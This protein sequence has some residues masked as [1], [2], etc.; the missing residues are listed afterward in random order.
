MSIIHK[1]FTNKKA[2]DVWRL[3]L[4][5]SFHCGAT[6]QQARYLQRLTLGG[7]LFLKPIITKIGRE[8]NISADFCL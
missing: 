8:S 6:L 3:V 4:K 2:Y 7:R 5:E 1:K